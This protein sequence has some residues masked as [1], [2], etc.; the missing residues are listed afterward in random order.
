M[1]CSDSRSRCVEA[2]NEREFNSL[3]CLD[4]PDPLGFSF[5]DNFYNKTCK[6]VNFAIP[7]TIFEDKAGKNREL[8]IISAQAG[9]VVVDMAEEKILWKQVIQA[10]NFTLMKIIP[11]TFTNLVRI[12]GV[13]GIRN[14]LIFVWK[15]SFNADGAFLAEIESTATATGPVSFLTSFYDFPTSTEVV[16]VLVSTQIIFY[17]LQDKA[18]TIRQTWSLTLPSGSTFVRMEWIRHLTLDRAAQV[19]SVGCFPAVTNGQRS[20]IMIT[21]DFNVHFYGFVLGNQG[22]FNI[23]LSPQA[24]LGTSLYYQ[25]PPTFSISSAFAYGECFGNID[26]PSQQILLTVGLYSTGT[27][28]GNKIQVVSLTEFALQDNTCIDEGNTWWLN[29]SGRRR[30]APNQCSLVNGACTSTEFYR[31]NQ[32]TCQPRI[33]A[34]ETTLSGRALQITSAT[35]TDNKDTTQ[36]TEIRNVYIENVIVTSIKAVDIIGVQEKLCTGGQRPIVSVMNRIQYQD[37]VLSTSISTNAQHLFTVTQKRDWEVD[38]YNGLIQICRDLARNPDAPNY[39]ARF[40]EMCKNAPSGLTIYDFIVYNSQCNGGWFCPQY[41]SRNPRRSISRTDDVVQPGTHTQRPT[42][43]NECEPG[44]FCPGQEDSLRRICPVGHKCPNFKMIVPEKCF[45]GNFYEN[46][47]LEEG[48]TS[49]ILRCPQGNI[50]KAPEK[51]TYAPPGYLV[52]I[53]NRKFVVKCT[54]GDLCTLGT[55]NASISSLDNSFSC[56]AGFYCPTT[57][58]LIPL[59]CQT[60]YDDKVTRKLNNFTEYCPAG[61]FGPYPHPCPAGFECPSLSVAKECEDGYFCPVGTQFAV[62]CPAGNYCPTPKAYLSCPKDY[63][64]RNA[65]QNPRPCQWLVYCPEGST[66]EK[67]AYGALIFQLCIVVVGFFLFQCVRIIYSAIRKKRKKKKLLAKGE[68]Y[69][70]ALTALAFD[71]EEYNE[72]EEAEERLLEESQR[73]LPKKNF[74]MDIKLSNLTLERLKTGKIMMQGVNAGFL[75]GRVSAVMGANKSDTSVVLDVLAGR[76]YYANVNGMIKVNGNEEAIMAEFLNI[77]GFV[78]RKDTMIPSFKVEENIRFA[79]H[80]RLPYMTTYSEITDKINMVLSVLGIEHLR[81]KHVGKKG[82]D[83]SQGLTNY[84]RK[85]VSIAMELVADPSLLLLEHPLDGLVAEEAYQIV[86]NLK[87]ISRSGV[88]VI[89]AVDKPRYEIFKQFDD[90]ILLGQTGET[91]YNGPAISVVKYFEELGFKVPDFKNPADYIID[92][93]NGSVARSGDDDFTSDKLASLWEIKQQEIG[94]PWSSKDDS[95]YLG[96]EN[97][98]DLPEKIDTTEDHLIKQVTEAEKN[99]QRPGL[100]AQFFIYWV[101]SSLEL[102]RHVKGQIFDFFFYIAIAG[103]MG[104]IYFNMD[105]I[106]PVTPVLQT[107]CPPFVRDRICGMPRLDN[108]G[109]ILAITSVCLSIAA[110]YSSF[111]IFAQDKNLYRKEVQQGV[112]KFSYF[113]GKI[114]AYMPMNL[115]LPFVF[116]AVWFAFIVPRA[117]FGAYYGLFVVIQMTWSA[118]G[119]LISIAMKRDH[120]GF[121]GLLGL[122]LSAI[123]SGYSP[124]LKT[125]SDSNSLYASFLI[126]LSPLSYAFQ[127]LYLLEI[128]FYRSENVDVNSALKNYGFDIYWL[129]W[130]IIVQLVFCFIFYLAAFIVLFFKD[131]RVSDYVKIITRYFVRKGTKKIKKGLIKVG[132]KDE[133]DQSLLEEQEDSE[134][135]NDDRSLLSESINAER[136]L[137]DINNEPEDQNQ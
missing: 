72:D 90:L 135:D 131:P 136:E 93:I 10:G 83:E 85:Q 132:E 50:C 106:G 87:I 41:G 80:A 37:R 7:I 112:N 47:C 8:L 13:S 115:I 109:I 111:K 110:M 95:Q 123:L 78:D 30:T 43:V 51:A 53:Q 55:A 100:T 88:N 32:G 76:A 54:T 94:K 4:T 59:P 60:M 42:K 1:N 124:T 66:S 16:A 62:S 113:F 105:F 128:E 33:Q 91:V 29:P 31:D 6:S 126:F 81:N 34:V 89:V 20:L 64:C 137:I 96:E 79:A 44:F 18:L 19:T 97:M 49:E 45:T 133:K 65:T 119:T 82:V 101:R 75:H 11:G 69:G 104:T 118:Y 73:S 125:F 57:D 134:D 84:Q 67:Y 99:R 58:T 56:P 114:V 107:V 103:L 2:P 23:N 5:S 25:A 15:L 127:S 12:V 117:N 92:I 24:T 98:E 70:E 130:T 3:N 61:T 35:S 36:G 108:L 17:Q 48:Q 28:T 121:Y 122:L 22:T 86:K 71:E 120:A 102:T 129:Y 52:G 9:L 27:N 68:G 63:F 77:T 40:R 21:T 38:S 46:S 74:T 14:D 116:Q 26:L 39:N